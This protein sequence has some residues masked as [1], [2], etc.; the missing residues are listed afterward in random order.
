MPDV[1]TV[2]EGAFE[3]LPQKLDVWTIAYT[4][5]IVIAAV[6]VS[7]VIL[8]LLNRRL[9]KSK[10]DSTLAKVIRLIV[11]LVVGVVC[12]LLICDT[13]GV[14][15]TS[16]LALFSVIALA[17][18]LAIQGVLANLAGGMVL[19]WARPFRVGDMIEVDGVL[20]KVKEATLM[21]TKI[22]TTDNKLVSIPNK[23]VSEAKVLNFSKEPTRRLELTFSASYDSPI[24]KVKEAVLEA[25]AANDLVLKEP[26]PVVGVAKYGASAIEYNLWAWCQGTDYWPAFYSVNE[27]LKK[28]LDKAGL[29]MTYD[30]LNVHMVDRTPKAGQ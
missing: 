7:R 26:E 24:D 21:Y 20:G 5:L 15:I 1:E 30:H 14:Q 19:L 25:L 9:K 2:V 6:V 11:K 29:E 16:L 22:N 3:G 12:V 8:A 27:G 4:L 28:A 18:S 17:L 10:L 23:I 13:L